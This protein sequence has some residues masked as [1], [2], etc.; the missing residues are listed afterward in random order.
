MTTLTSSIL[1]P[2]NYRL[3]YCTDAISAANDLAGTQITEYIHT[4]IHILYTLPTMRAIVERKH[5]NL[6]R[7]HSRNG[8]GTGHI[9]IK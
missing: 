6:R 7:R 1:Q 2:A 5:L 4:Y 9:N 8:K 3:H